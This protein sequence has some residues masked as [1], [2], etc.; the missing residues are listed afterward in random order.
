VKTNSVENYIITQAT[1]V[2]FWLSFSMMRDSKVAKDFMFLCFCDLCVDICYDSLHKRSGGRR[3]QRICRY[4]LMSLAE[5]E[6]RLSVS[7]RNNIVQSSVRVVTRTGY[8]RLLLVLNEILKIEV[9][10][11]RCLYEFE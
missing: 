3:I 6:V 11:N 1:R 2:G 10:S 4:S 8:Q 5:F 9:L 7:G